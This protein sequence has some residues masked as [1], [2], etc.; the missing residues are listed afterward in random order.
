[1]SEP[2]QEETPTTPTTAAPTPPFTAS[3]HTI[4]EASSK[5]GLNQGE[6]GLVLGYAKETM[7]RK[8]KVDATAQSLYSIG[9]G[10]FKSQL[11]SRVYT[12]AMDSER[13]DCMDASKFLI[14]R[15][16]AQELREDG[17]TV[18]TREP[19]VVNITM[20]TRSR[21]EIIRDSKKVEV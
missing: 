20:E 19:T 15:I 4:I 8:M 7:S 5:L 3:Q 21:E 17:V 6:I 2:S 14:N 9:R 1:M 11:M 12:R 13:K 10:N 18:D 16:D